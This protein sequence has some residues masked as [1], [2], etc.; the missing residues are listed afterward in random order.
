MDEKELSVTENLCGHSG[1]KKENLCG[2][3]G[4]QQENLCKTNAGVR[5][6]NLAAGGCSHPSPPPPPKTAAGG[7]TVTAPLELHVC[8]GLNACK[9]HDRFGTNVCA[10][11]GYCAT[12]S[13]HHCRTLNDCRG[14]G[15]CGLFGTAED[16][17]T[18]GANDCAW[19]GACAVPVEAE[20]FSTQGA[21][22][23]KSVWVLARR[24]FE[25]RMRKANRNFGDSPY[26]C[27][28][29]AA[30]LVTSLG[31]FDSCGSAGSKS[32]SF[33]Y[34]D[35]AADAQELCKNSNPHVLCGTPKQADGTEEG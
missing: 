16:D 25:E 8:M 6:G 32:C 21:N 31:S 26:A 17:E 18:P 3:G 34:N 14:Q 15:G 12:A 22:K 10:G 11:M 7:A 9:G 1:G 5:G 13:V 24:L 4:G 30:W 33:G 23:G 29:P 28:P 19:Q 2:H 27:G 35:P 20:R